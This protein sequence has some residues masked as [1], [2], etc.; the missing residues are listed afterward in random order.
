MDDYD[1]VECLR[2]GKTWYSKQFEEEG[3]VPKTCTTCFR[4]SVR[5]I[6]PPP[7]ALDKLKD[8]AEYWKTEIPER[9]NERKHQ[10]VLWK[11]NNSVL[12]NM[13]AAV[14]VMLAIVSVMAYILFA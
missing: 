2:C 5:E 3:K 9:F 7:T 12:L 10:V 4:D 11:E 8:R 14:L 6:P 1:N 13:L